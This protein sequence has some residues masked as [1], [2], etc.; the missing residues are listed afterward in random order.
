MAVVD[1]GSY[2]LGEV[3]I[4]LAV[5]IGLLNPL[6]LQL[7]LFLFGQFGLGPFLL[8]I[9]VQFQ[10]AISATLQ[11]SIGITDPLAALRALLA[12][13]IQLQASIAIALSF[14]LPMITIQAAAQLSAVA[15]LAG[16]LS[17]K[18]G[19]IQ[20]LLAAGLAV[21]IPALQ[22]VA[23]MAATLSAGPIHL[24]TFTGDTLLNSG[25]QIQTKF[26]SGLGP[27]DPITPGTLVD[28]IIIVCKD[29]IVFQALGVILKTS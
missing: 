21:K 16:S 26:A 28:G 18:I 11:L 22:F 5:G 14:P 8:D 19:G 6:L 27:S 13:L 9:Q 10:A 24:L 4:G 25:A 1:V 15:S 23:K 20:A 29:P 3:N 7:D 2:T 17:L 12:A